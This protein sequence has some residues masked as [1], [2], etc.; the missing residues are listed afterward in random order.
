[1]QS[2]RSALICVHERS[3]AENRRILMID[4]GLARKYVDDAGNVHSQARRPLDGPA[5]C[6]VLTRAARHS[7]RSNAA[8]RGSSKYASIYTHQNEDQGRRDDVWSLLY[9]LVEFVDG[10]LPWTEVRESRQLSGVTPL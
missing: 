10:V 7:Q 3:G 1:M 2:W 9:L 4:Y 8:F 5:F 6:A